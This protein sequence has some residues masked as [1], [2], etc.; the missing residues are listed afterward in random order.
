MLASPH[1]LNPHL[2]LCIA[3]SA[4]LFLYI[5]YV[6]FY[7]HKVNIT[8]TDTSDIWTK[9]LLNAGLKHK[10]IEKLYH[11]EDGWY[12][13]YPTGKRSL[14]IGYGDSQEE[15]LKFETVCAGEDTYGSLEEQAREISLAIR[16]GIHPE[17][18]IIYNG[19]D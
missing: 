13:Q 6:F 11:D 1:F 16:H 19:S 14:C 10:D 18:P 9:T 7:N 17:C 5:V 3:I 12:Y 8:D 2:Y 4:I 15:C